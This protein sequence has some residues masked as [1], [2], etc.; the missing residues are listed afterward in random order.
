MKKIKPTQPSISFKKYLH[1]KPSF[2]N[3]EVNETKSNINSS[4][5]EGT[6]KATLGIAE[7]GAWNR[8]FRMRVTSKKTGKKIDLDFQFTQTENTN[9]S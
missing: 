9:E 4:I 1:I 2:E 8:K 6:S 3:L 7:E 5:L